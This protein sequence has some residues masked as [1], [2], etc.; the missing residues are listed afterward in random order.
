MLPTGLLCKKLD[1]TPFK[2]PQGS[3][4][5]HL[6]YLRTHPCPNLLSRYPFSPQGSVS[7]LEKMSIRR[8]DTVDYVKEN[9]ILLE[10]IGKIGRGE[11]VSVAAAPSP[12]GTLFPPS[13]CNNLLA[14]FL[15]VYY[16]ACRSKALRSHVNQSWFIFSLSC[17]VRDLWLREGADDGA[18]LP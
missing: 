4:M 13:P 1:P 2:N 5:T 11:P 8:A 7:V 9:R 14:I 15:G 10:N 16:G 18:D 17:S 12:M 3:P 6:Q